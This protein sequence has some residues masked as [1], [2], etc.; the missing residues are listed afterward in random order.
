MRQLRWAISVAVLMSLAACADPAG[1]GGPSQPSLTGT[2]WILA[3]VS[4]DGELNPAVDRTASLTFGSDDAMFGS[5]GCNQFSGTWAADGDSLSLEVGPMT[6]MA[7]LE[8]P[9]QAQETAVIA[10]LSETAAYAVS[11]ET[12][13][14]TGEGGDPLAT[15]SAAVSDLAGTSWQATGVNNGAGAVVSTTTTNQLTLVFGNDGT[16]SGF[17]GCASFTGVYTADEQHIAITSLQPEQE[18]ASAEQD[19]YLAALG[20]ATTYRVNGDRLELR[21]DA[22]ALQAGFTQS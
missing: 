19:Q 1:P 7:C 22:G 2:S 14:L 15:Y 6:L 16:A 20:A 13:T 9:R 11:G 3:E 12:L 5:T 10:A 18:C 21:D 8:E 4:I 17:A